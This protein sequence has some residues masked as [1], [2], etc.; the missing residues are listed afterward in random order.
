VPSRKRAGGAAPEA[1]IRAV[2]VE[3]DG[4]LVR[5]LA[6]ELREADATFPGPPI[7]IEWAERV[8]V[9]LERV[10]A[11]V[12][13]VLLIDLS[14]PDARGL[15][16]V[17]RARSEVPDLPLLVLLP[18]TEPE[19][20][21]QTLRAGAEDCLV[22][23]EVDGRTLSRAIRY[24]IER[25]RARAA[26]HILSLVDELTGLYNRRGFFSLADQRVKLARR[27]AE[28]LAPPRTSCAARSATRTSSRAS[29]ATSSPRSP[30]IRRAAAQRPSCVGWRPT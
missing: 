17:M 7:E 4:R 20:A 8:A 11:R 19:L 25:N 6:F 23:S 28:G 29:A 12:P 22:R 3:D 18:R 1:R 21:L 13:D 10:A 26:Q 5:S 2:L 27:T 9:G 24:A 30:P 15:E 14:V 16:T